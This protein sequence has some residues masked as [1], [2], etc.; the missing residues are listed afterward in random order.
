[1]LVVVPLLF[2]TNFQSLVDRV[3]AVDCPAEVQIERL[4][5]RDHIDRELASSMLAQQLDNR[6][7]LARAH[8]SIDNSGNGSNLVAQVA[9]LHRRYLRLAA[10]SE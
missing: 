7:R 9:D 6:T 5:K 10:A 8:D 1:M 3:L 4:M 2:E